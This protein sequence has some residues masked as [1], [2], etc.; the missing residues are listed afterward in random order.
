MFFQQDDEQQ[1][2]AAYQCKADSRLWSS[3]FTITPT[4]TTPEAPSATFRLH[5][6]RSVEATLEGLNFNS[7]PPA[8]RILG[9]HFADI[10]FPLGPRTIN[11]WQL[12]AADF[13]ALS[14]LS[15]CLAVRIRENGSED[16]VPKCR[17]G[18]QLMNVIAIS[19]PFR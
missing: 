2:R 7:S 18:I 11:L 17:A 12:F 4:I 19:C 6:G 9:R 3:H 5:C 14:H 1:E 13:S 8:L 15:G 16:E 10:L